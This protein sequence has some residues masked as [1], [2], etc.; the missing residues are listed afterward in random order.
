MRYQ[1]TRTNSERRRSTD[2]DTGFA[3][4]FAYVRTKTCD[5]APLSQVDL[6]LSKTPPCDGTAP[7][8]AWEQ[9]RVLNEHVASLP[10]DTCGAD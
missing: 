4:A 7:V 10:Q 5:D 2:A 8:L 9:R 1:L 3:A 6:T